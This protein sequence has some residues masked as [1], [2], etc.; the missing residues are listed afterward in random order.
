MKFSDKVIKLRKRYGYTQD[1]FAAEVGVSRQSVYKWENGT[2]YP[3][4]EKLLKI[5]RTL[6]ITVDDL[7][8]EEMGL[9]ENGVAI[10]MTEEEAARVVV[11]RLKTPTRKPRTV[12]EDPPAEAEEQPKEEAVKEDTPAE[13][14]EE[15]K[16]EAAKEEEISQEPAVESA[17]AEEAPVAPAEEAP[18]E[19]APAEEAEEEK[20]PEKKRGG[21]FGW[22]RRN[23]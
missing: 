9:D 5:A 11:K 6:Q 21:L 3:E 16:E 18:A 19:E 15:P 22:F 1:I 8:N 23:K 12:K 14:E 2:S 13:T 20:K 10:P 4:V 7:L 17:P